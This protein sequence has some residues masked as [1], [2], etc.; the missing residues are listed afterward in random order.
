MRCVPCENILN[1]SRHGD[2]DSRHVSDIISRLISSPS[3]SYV[4]LKVFRVVRKTVRDGN[5]MKWDKI[6][7]LRHQKGMTQA[8]HSVIR[9]ESEYEKFITLKAF[10]NL[11]CA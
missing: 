5:F 9:D 1:D 7:G 4:T 11:F 10:S 8:Q 3:G 6:N 2:G